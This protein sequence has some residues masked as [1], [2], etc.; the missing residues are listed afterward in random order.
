MKYEAKSK[1]MVLALS[2]VELETLIRL[3][4]MGKEHRH[5]ATMLRRD[6]VPTL[7]TG[8]RAAAI[9]QHD[10]ASKARAAAADRRA[11]GKLDANRRKNIVVDGHTVMA[12]LGDYIDMSPS[13]DYTGWMP[14]AVVEAQQK[15]P[16]QAEIRRDV[17][18][19]TVLT[20]EAQRD[21]DDTRMIVGGDCTDDDDARGIV[22]M[23]R[24]ILERNER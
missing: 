15:L 1:G 3:A 6:L 18:N 2:I 8:L 5:A 17:W 7:I 13:P 14:L 22:P 19:V 16:A 21:I 23:A 4:E 24:R 20:T 11:S 12:T 9:A 10:K